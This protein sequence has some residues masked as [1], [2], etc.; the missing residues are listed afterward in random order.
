MEK[1]SSN[2]S[3]SRSRLNS[4]AMAVQ[5]RASDSS[6]SEYNVG[7]AAG[8]VG[9]LLI[10]SSLPPELWAQGMQHWVHHPKVDWKVDCLRI[11]VLYP[12]AGS[13][14]QPIP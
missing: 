12:T 2:T 1:C 13:V 11:L 14:V 6:T 7:K 4:R 10:D 9:Q 8:A 5:R 3:I